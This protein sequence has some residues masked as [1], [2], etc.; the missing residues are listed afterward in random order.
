MEGGPFALVQN[1]SAVSLGASPAKPDFPCIISSYLIIH[2]L[3]AMQ[4]RRLGDFFQSSSFQTASRPSASAAWELAPKPTWQMNA[5]C[6][7]NLCGAAAIHPYIMNVHPPVISLR[8]RPEMPVSEA[9]RVMG[10]GGDSLHLILM[11]LM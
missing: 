3:H 9:Q 11:C 7:G 5:G 4:T 1:V 2:L 6:G 8:R 10:S